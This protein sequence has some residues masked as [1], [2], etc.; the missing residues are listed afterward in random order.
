MQEVNFLSFT[1]VTP[2]PKADFAVLV[3]NTDLGPV[4]MIVT[5]KDFHKLTNSELFLN[6]YVSFNDDQ[7]KPKQ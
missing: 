1:P 3:L 5:I 6:K 7:Y 2:S 4:Q